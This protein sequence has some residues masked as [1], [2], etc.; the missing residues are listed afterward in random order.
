MATAYTIV[1][2][3]AS[4]K[5]WPSAATLLRVGVPLKVAR[6]YAR[7]RRRFTVGLRRWARENVN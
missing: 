3:D 4:P 5:R 7:I 2:L 6:D 1:V